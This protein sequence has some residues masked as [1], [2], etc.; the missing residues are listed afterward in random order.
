MA[1]TWLDIQCMMIQNVG[2]GE[3]CSRYIDF[4]VYVM[5]YASILYYTKCT[6]K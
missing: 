2:T 1:V 6:D 5:A 4:A 3:I